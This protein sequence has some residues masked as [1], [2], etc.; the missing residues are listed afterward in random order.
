MQFEIRTAI[1]HGNQPET[2][3]YDGPRSGPQLVAESCV[4]VNVQAELRAIHGSEDWV[5]GAERI[6]RMLVKHSGLRVALVTMRARAQWTE[7]KTP[8]RIS[9]Q[10]LEGC[11]RF[12]TA[13]RELTLGIGDLLVLDSNVTHSVEALDDTAFLLTLS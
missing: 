7:H 3:E 2:R 6:T 12:R 10:P 4:V 9:V 1:P 11:I 13:D 8:S 5:K